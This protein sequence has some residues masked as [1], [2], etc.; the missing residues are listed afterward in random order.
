MDLIRRIVT[1]HWIIALVLILIGLALYLPGMDELGYYRDDWN[2]V[3]NTEANG[4]DYLITHYE[5]DRPADGYLLAAAYKLFG[6]NPQPYLYINLACRLLSAVFFA[7]TLRLI[8]PTPRFAAFGAG[9][10]Y[11]IFPGYL[12]QVDGIAYLPHQLAMLAI[13]LSIYL[14]VLA[15]TI[16]SAGRK[17]MVQVVLVIVAVLLAIGEMFLMEYYIGMEAL[18]FLLIWA[19]L[20][21]RKPG[22]PVKNFFA[23][24]GRFLPYLIGAGLFFMWRSFAFEATRAGTDVRSILEPFLAAPKYVGAVWIQKL[25]MNLFKLFVGSW[26]I[27]PY[28]LLNGINVR[29]FFRA[30][31]T[32]IVPVFLFAEMF[33][34]MTRER[35]GGDVS[36]APLGAPR[37]RLR[38]QIQWI[39]IGL[40]SGAVALL[41]LIMA[42]REITFASSL[43]R[44]TY[45]AA[46]SA[47]MALIG[48]I[49]LIEGRMVKWTL[50][51]LTVLFGA[52][53]QRVNQMNY[54]AQTKAENE[55][56]WQVSWRIPDLKDGTMVLLHNSGFS[57]EEDYENFAPLMMIYRPKQSNTTLTSDLINESSIRNVLMGVVNDRVVRTI[58]LKRNFG[59]VLALTKPSDKSCLQVIDGE[60]P[61]YSPS[62]Y[63][64][65]SQLG[66]ASDP[67]LIMLDVDGRIPSGKYFGAEPA[68]GWCYSYA[69]MGIAQQRG[70]WEAVEMIADRAI[71]AGQHGE[72]P[73][74]WIPVVQAFA[75]RGRQDDARGYLEILKTSPYLRYESCQY[76]R[77]AGELLTLD[78]TESAGNRWLVTELCDD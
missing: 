5:S 56:W 75:Y 20:V 76:F 9:A 13:T 17:R 35:N 10:L 65:I 68:H 1:H 15:L 32:V 41:L 77:N 72:D 60:N 45:H 29:V 61:I 37:P 62:D 3:F 4:A 23:A 55:F 36:D 70:D 59:Q 51:T 8:W 19:C 26:A 14:S 57:A 63:S 58:H 49:A 73:V 11:L 66:D 28:N 6:P 31:G 18:R 46:F 25:F 24:I 7:W 78:K 27:P 50:L 40:V 16:E 64:R 69:Q 43:D 38:W 54:I 48:L 2:N 22:S 74:E 44:F 47:V 30:L 53:T 67:S 71:E 34:T 52:L 21:N 39:W 12:R 33:L 42:T